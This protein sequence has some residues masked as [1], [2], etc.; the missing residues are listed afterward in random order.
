MNWKAVSAWIVATAGLASAQ[1]AAP[2]SKD[3]KTAAAPAETAKGQIT[4]FP[5]PALAGAPYSSTGGSKHTNMAYCPLND[6]LYVSGGDWTRSAT[7][8]TW[9]MDM[10]N[11]SWRKDVGDPVYPTLPA[12]S[13][14]QDG[15]GF[16]WDAKRKKFLFWPGAY[17]A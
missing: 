17:F 1:S 4:S 11:G 14:A 9:S 10:K 2:G 5:L 6:R 15:M 12:P 8:G 3:K 13:A 7:D 16:V